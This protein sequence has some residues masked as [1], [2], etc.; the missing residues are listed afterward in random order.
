MK[1]QPISF[2]KKYKKPRTG[3]KEIQ[4]TQSISQMPKM[5]PQEYIT[6]LKNQANSALSEAQK[7]KQTAN[8][9][10]IR[11]YEIAAKAKRNKEFKR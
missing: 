10:K 8:S 5:T 11:S 3:K 6:L 9:I 4:K 2:E 7:I 1:I